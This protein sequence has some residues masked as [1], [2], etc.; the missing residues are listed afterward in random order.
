[1]FVRSGTVAR[2]FALG[3]GICAN[4]RAIPRTFV[5]RLFCNATKNWLAPRDR[6]RKGGA[7]ASCRS[8]I[9]R[10]QNAVVTSIRRAIAP[11]I[12]QSPRGAFQQRRSALAVLWPPAQFCACGDPRPRHTGVM[13]SGRQPGR[14][15]AKQP[16]SEFIVGDDP[17]SRK[18]RLSIKCRPLIMRSYFLVI[19]VHLI[20]RCV[21][22]Q[23]IHRL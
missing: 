18:H 22:C 8:S 12:W 3:K 15:L 14:V 17:G 21:D 13:A 1:L 7:A 11:L 6:G 9:A 10:H 2:W 5:R 4:V 23:T 20:K 16:K 19:F